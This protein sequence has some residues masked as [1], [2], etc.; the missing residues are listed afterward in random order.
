M[1]LV[2]APELLTVLLHVEALEDNEVLTV[3]RARYISRISDPKHKSTL[4]KLQTSQEVRNI[5]FSNIY[6]DR[7]STYWIV[8][9]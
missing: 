7:N 1:H 2:T 4:E 5:E 3:E 8:V 9:K 6:V